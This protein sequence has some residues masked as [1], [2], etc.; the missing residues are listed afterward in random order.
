[1]S[2]TPPRAQSLRAF[3]VFAVVAYVIQLAGCTQE[4]AVD[5]RTAPI[6]DP[7]TQHPMVIELPMPPPAPRRVAIP[8]A[9][10]A[11]MAQKQASIL[12]T[13]PRCEPYRRETIGVG[14]RDGPVTKGSSSSSLRS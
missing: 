13:D 11:T 10:A 12:R 9:G 14:A 7:R 8:I 4:A 3:V 1:M 2:S 5:P 6:F